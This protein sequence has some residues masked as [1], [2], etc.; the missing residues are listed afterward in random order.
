MANGYVGLAVSLAS[1][2]STY[3]IKPPVALLMT[4]RN[5]RRTEE[6]QF[7]SEST[8]VVYPPLGLSKATIV[9]I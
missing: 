7:K 5:V 4:V 9:R 3:Q 6:D 1:F 8:A 2:A